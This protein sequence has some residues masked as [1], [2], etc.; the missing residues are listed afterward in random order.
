MKRWER[1]VRPLPLRARPMQDES[2][3]SFVMRL[4]A[5]NDFP[6]TL[7]FRTIG[8]CIPGKHVVGRDAILNTPALDRLS[9]L[10]RT[11]A[12]HLTRALPGLS[13]TPNYS[14]LPA[15][16]P[17][18]RFFRLPYPALACR[19]CTLRHGPGTAVAWENRDRDYTRYVCT[20]H[21]RWINSTPQ[22]HLATAPEI[23]AAQ[24]EYDQLAARYD[25]SQA[26]SGLFQA[27]NITTRW[28]QQK[29]HPALTR[30]WTARAKSIGATG[31]ISAA[32]RFP[33]MI[34][35]A[36]LLVHPG[37]REFIGLASPWRVRHFF[38][39]TAHVTGADYEEFFAA[40]G[41]EDPLSKWVLSLRSN[42]ADRPQAPSRRACSL[43]GIPTPAI[44]ESRHFK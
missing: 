29:R 42:Y 21:R 39:H 4:A 2:V 20:R 28:L 31:P 15:S 40:A 10:S 37:W 16:R 26:F 9:I 35:L 23:V 27:W 33:E 17:S 7:L 38:R 5:A 36:E 34:R 11:P 30:R 1:P 3:V 6:S 32:A 43:R 19:T 13:H 41:R 44:P 22:F 12:A 18:V 8:D 24:H 25:Q 14:P